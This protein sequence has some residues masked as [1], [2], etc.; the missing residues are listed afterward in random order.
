M[1]REWRDAFSPLGL[2][3]APPGYTRVIVEKPF[4]RD[5]DS[6]RELSR[7]LAE[8]LTEDQ[9]YRHAPEC[10][11]SVP[12]AGLTRHACSIDH[13]LGKELIENLTVLR[14]SNLV[15]QPLWNRQFIRNVQIIF[16]EPFGTEGRGGYFDNYGII[17]DIMQNHLLQVMALFAMEQ[18]A[19]MDA[20]DIR[21]EKVKLLR[22][23]RPLSLDNVVTG[24]YK[25]SNPGS[26]RVF[27]GYLDDPTVPA[28]SLCPTFAAIAFFIDNP[29]W[30][31][32]PFLMKAGKALDKR[33]AEI[34]I[35]FHPVPGSLY[36]DYGTAAELTNELVIRI[37]PN[38]SIYLRIN[39]KVPG[40]GLRLD[41]SNLDLHYKS[42]YA[43]ELIDAYERLILDVVNGDKRLFIRNDELE[44][45]WKLFTP[46]L[47]ELEKSR[48]QPELYAYG[49]RGPE[50]ASYLA[51]KFDCRFG[52]VE[53]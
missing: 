53:L 50:G 4:G 37:Q 5:L 28:G 24:Q 39:N 1:H 35:Q 36:K 26:G 17:R 32:V 42:R 25:K 46:L 43:V 31:G 34:R 44:V 12:C 40:L 9:I 2:P 19:S 51:A 29:R 21:N 3:R 18:P 13:Y 16:S 38:E 33:C 10:F 49:S 27:P 15:F 14:F 22:A 11:S 20:E 52:D 48:R 7:G 45:A 30:D 23:I 41:R 6:S 8:D 47:A